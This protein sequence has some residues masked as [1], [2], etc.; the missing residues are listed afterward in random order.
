GPT[1]GFARD[2]APILEKHGVDVVFQG[3]AHDYERTSPIKGGRVDPKGVVYFLA[4]DGGAPLNKKALNEPWSAA[5]A[6]RYGFLDVRV[7]ERS[8]EVRAVGLDGRVF[9]RWRAEK[10]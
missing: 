9:D 3:H 6:D 5:F 2:L 10:R 8:F 7:D 4:G 1:P